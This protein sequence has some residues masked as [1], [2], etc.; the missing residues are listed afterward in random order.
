LGADWM[1]LLVRA[2]RHVRPRGTAVGDER[3]WEVVGDGR[4][5]HGGWQAGG[6]ICI[7]MCVIYY[8]GLWVVT[9]RRGGAR[10]GQMKLEGAPGC[11]GDVQVRQ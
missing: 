11:S 3:R 9:C 1:L 7:C 8:L 10:S 4:G 2:T 6:G 5:V